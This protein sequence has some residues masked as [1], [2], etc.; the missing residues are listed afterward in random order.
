M[1]GFASAILGMLGDLTASIIKRQ[2]SIK[3]FGHIMPGHGG[4]L[5]RFDSVL[6]VAPFMYMALGYLPLITR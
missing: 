5:D 1:L 3:D 6:F 4:V 2:C